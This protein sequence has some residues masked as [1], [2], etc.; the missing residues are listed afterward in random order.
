MGLHESQSRMWEN[1]VGRRASRS[2][3]SSIR[4]L[5]EAFPGQF[6]DVEL[7]EFYR[8]I[9]KVQPSLIRV[10]ADEATYNLHIILRFELEQE[11]L[12]GEL[13]SR[14]CPRPGT[15]AWPSTSGIDVPDDAHGV[16]QD[17][18]WSGGAIGYFPTY[19]LG[20]VISVQLWDQLRARSPD[21]DSSSSRASSA[22]SARGYARTCTGTGA[23][24]RRR[25]CSSGSWA[26]DGL[27]AVP[28]LPQGEARRD[29]RAAGRNRRRRLDLAV[30]KAVDGVVVDQ[31]RLPA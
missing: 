11:I 30:A 1:L 15:R 10:E 9:N 6:G 8:A 17:V 27:R 3:A 20:N 23:S 21:L 5:Q 18:H 14:T 28:A 26:G 4:K 19:A 22:S 12:A 2:G 31:T 29:L 25:R 24:T 7:D 16:L 13:R